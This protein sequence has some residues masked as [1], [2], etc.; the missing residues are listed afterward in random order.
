MTCSA[1]HAG[2]LLLPLGFASLQLDLPSE[3]GA[4]VL[5]L[6]HGHAAFHAD[7]H[8]MYGRWGIRREEPLENRHSGSPG[9]ADR[10]LALRNKPRPGYIRPNGSLAPGN[11]G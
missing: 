1:P 10:M 2:G 9:Y 6:G 4:P 11:I 8:A 5:V 3:D 7:T